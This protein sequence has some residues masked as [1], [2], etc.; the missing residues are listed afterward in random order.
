MAYCKVETNDGYTIVSNVLLRDERLTLKAKGLLSL[1][2]SLPPKWDMTIE[3]L[4]K[5]CIE[6]S[7]TISGILKELEAAGYLS[8]YRER[9]GNGRYGHMIYHFFSTPSHKRPIPKKPKRKKPVQEKPI[10][11]KSGQ[12]SKEAINKEETNKDCSDIL[13]INQDDAMDEMRI[14]RTIVC[15]NID[16]EY[17]IERDNKGIVDEIVEIMLECICS[18]AQSLVIGKEAVPKEL[19]KSR[20]LKLDSSHIEYVLYSLNNN[21]TKVRNIKSYLKTTL[22]NA[23]TTINSFYTAE[24]NHDLYGNRN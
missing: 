17:L 21:T 11:E 8:R 14:Y 6:C 23:P 4:S 18:T 24:V 12:L 1:I 16:Y 22:Y 9:L 10:R 5:I 15:E 20:F 7:D 3:G 19:V 13:S 2:L